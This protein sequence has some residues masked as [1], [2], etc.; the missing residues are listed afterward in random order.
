MWFSS[1]DGIHDLSHHN[2]NTVCIGGV[3]LCM[4]K[5][6][7]NLRTTTTEPLEHMFGTARSWKREFTINEFIHYSNKLE[8]IMKNIIQNDI[9]TTTSSKGYMNGFAG[10]ASAVKNLQEKLKKE[11][12]TGE[13]NGLSIDVDY[14]KPICTQIEPGLIAVIQRTQK[15]IIELMK[16]FGIRKVSRYCEPISS[17]LDICSIYQQSTRDIKSH[18]LLR[19][20]KSDVDETHETEVMQQLADLALTVGEHEMIVDDTL[21]DNS[22]ALFDGQSTY[23]VEMMRGSELVY[24]NLQMFYKF[25]RN[26]VNKDN[27]GNMLQLMKQSISHSFE[28]KQTNGSISNLQKCKSLN[29][30]WFNAS[31]ETIEKLPETSLLERD[32]IYEKNGTYYRILTIFTKS[33]GKWRYQQCHEKGPDMRIH[34]RWRT[35]VG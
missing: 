17:I 32:Y 4:Q 35:S 14:T 16:I 11:T 34:V 21:Q 22:A 33:Y 6:V 9:K 15:P 5:R 8:I 12:F 24:F 1:L 20:K 19:Y 26:E 13:E 3:F 10:F 7:R 25:I 31:K 23:D 29:Q 30:R 27:V 2:F 18:F 28:N